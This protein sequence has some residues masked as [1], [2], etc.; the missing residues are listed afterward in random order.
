M[1]YR[2]LCLWMVFL[3]FSIGAGAAE[4]GRRG[5]ENGRSEVDARK[6]QMEQEAQAMASVV[7]KALTD[8]LEPVQKNHRPSQDLVQKSQLVLENTKRYF[9]GF[10]D[11]P[12]AQFM[13]LQAWTA[14]YQ[15]NSDVAL[16]WSLR[17]CRTDEASQDTWISQAVF[18]L[19][20]GRPPALPRIEE[21]RP[22]PQPERTRA[23]R[24]RRIDTVSE[25]KPQ[26][27]S[28]KGILEFDLL[29]LNIRMFREQFER[30]EF[31]TTAGE[32]IAYTPGTDALCMLFWE[33]V[34]AMPEDTRN[35]QPQPANG[36]Q[37]EVQKAIQE[38]MQQVVPEMAE[39]MSMDSGDFYSD[40]Q[41]TRIQSQRNYFEVLMS[42]CKDAPE[43]KFLQINTFKPSLPEAVDVLPDDN[44]GPIPTVIAAAP[45]SNAQ[46]FAGLPM[47]KPF[48]VIV[49]KEG[50]VRYAGTAAD[51][52]PAFILTE[53]TG[54]EIDL[55]KQ[56]QTEVYPEEMMDPMMMEMPAGRDAI[57]PNRPA[58][59]PNE[60]VKVKKKGKKKRS[61]EPRAEFGDFP[62]QSIEE[63]VR[64]DKL[65]QSA[66]MHIEESRK[67]HMKNPKQG[68][69]DARK[70][71]SEFP[72]TEYAERARE[73]LRR[74][75][76]RWKKRHNITD[77]ELGY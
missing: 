72:N 4:L 75:P 42:A 71:L 17:A 38:A 45:Q 15:D 37:D 20:N 31:Q 54:V 48:M 62:T 34:P 68:I 63:G 8:L 2:I 67:I 47:A 32:K 5:R 60:P 21:P 1:K 52:V 23:R 39:G 24:P 51:F 55:A 46:Q 22:E 3:V 76:D 30:M 25:P 61:A 43:I 9:P 77:E 35:P 74:V 13:L 36:V 44:Q 73:L 40:S 41:K 69:E 6:Q 59:D 64:A 53:L 27:Y 16:N 29:G 11:K 12:K 70:V 33:D 49:D 26:P 18:G 58:S 66:Q 10:E 19:L 50:S 56:S 28:E 7:Q 14:F 57:D 65:L